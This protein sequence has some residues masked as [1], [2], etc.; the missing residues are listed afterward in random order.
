MNLLDAVTWVAALVLILGSV[1]V[2]LWFLFD[3]R[4]M[5]REERAA[6][7]GRGPDDVA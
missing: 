1:A 6:R 7:A 2:F 4:R 3:A 5:L